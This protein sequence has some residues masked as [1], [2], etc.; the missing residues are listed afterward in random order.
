MTTFELE[1]AAYA[2]AHRIYNG[3][4]TPDRPCPGG[5]RSRMI[6]RIA[7]EI[8]TAF[9][10]HHGLASSGSGASPEVESVRHSE[11][12]SPPVYVANQVRFYETLRSQR[13]M[14]DE[15]PSGLQQ[16]RQWRDMRHPY[17]DGSPSP[18]IVPNRPCLK[19]AMPEQFWA[20][21]LPSGEPIQPAHV[22]PMA[23]D[24]AAIPGEANP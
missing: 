20:H 19:C 15:I 23:S 6:D 4:P 21:R 12:F 17:D 9:S 1:V 16:T 24:E 3:L 14:A 11:Y 18:G 10:V 13:I 7:E 2:A 5:Y 22:E 8:K